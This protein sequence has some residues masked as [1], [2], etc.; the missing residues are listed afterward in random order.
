MGIVNEMGHLARIIHESSSRKWR[1]GARDMREE[2]DSRD[3]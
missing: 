1:S 2:R 3:V